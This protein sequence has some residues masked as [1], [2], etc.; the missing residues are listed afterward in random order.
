MSA[1]PKVELLDSPM[2]LVDC[3]G[4]KVS[5]VGADIRETGDKE[6]LDLALIVADTPC[7]AA[8]VACNDG[9]AGTGS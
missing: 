5:G 6:Q 8:G 3:P 4:F 9:C 2:G 1:H 7:P